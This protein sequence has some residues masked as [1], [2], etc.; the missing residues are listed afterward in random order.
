MRKGEFLNNAAEF[1]SKPDI[2]SA[3]DDLCRVKTSFWIRTNLVLDI[4]AAARS[5]AA[6]CVCLILQLV[7]GDMSAAH[8]TTYKTV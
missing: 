2:C 5:L 6:S 8:L 1:N 3:V 7:I 4:K